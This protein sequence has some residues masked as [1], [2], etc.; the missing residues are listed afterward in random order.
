MAQFFIERPV[1]SWVIAISIMLFGALS[2]LTLPVSMYPDIAP[3]VVS[4]SATYVGATAQTLESS[5]TQVI[6]QQLQGLDG[7]MYFSATSDVSGN[8][9][10]QLTFDPSVN[11]DIAQ[12]QVMN[13]VQL[14]MSNLPEE[15]QNAGVKVEK[16]STAFMCMF[17]FISTDGSMK[18]SDIV[19]YVGT[20][21]SDTLARVPGVGS[22]RLYGSKHAIRIWLDPERLLAY[23]LVP[24]DIKEAVKAQNAQVSAGQLGDLP[25]TDDTG[26]NIVISAQEKMTTPEEFQKVILRTN[27][28]GSLLRLED[29][30]RVEMGQERYDTLTRYNGETAAG[31]GVNLASGANALDTMKRLV[32]KLEQ[33][34]PYFPAGMDYRIVFDTTP[35]VQTSIMGVVETL[36]EAIRLVFLVLLVFL[37]NWRATLIPSLAVPVVLLGTFAVLAACGFSVNT[38]TLFGMVLAIGLL[39]DDAIV[40]VENVERLMTTEKLSPRDATKK[41]M[42]QITG[43]IT[44]IA[45]VLAAVFLPMAFFSGSVGVI[46]RQFSITIVSAMFLSVATAMSF[47]PSLCATLL[48]GH[49]PGVHPATPAGCTTNLSGLAG[50]FNRRFA[51]L[52]KRYLSCVAAWLRHPKLCLLLYVLFLAAMAELFHILPTGFLP[53]EDQG[54]LQVTFILPQTSPQLQTVEVVKNIEK[55]FMEQESDVV[56]RMIMSLGFSYSGEGQ[57]TGQ[58]FITLRDWSERHEASRRAEAVVARANRHFADLKEARVLVTLPPA[59]SG[60]GTSSG[61]D[62]QLEDRAGLGNDAL[63][64]AQSV[65]LEQ[66][67]QSPLLSTMRMNGTSDAPQLKLHVDREKAGML[68]VSLSDVNELISTA[69][70]GSYFDRFIDN[71]SVKRVYTQADAPYR[72]NT[73]DF[74]RWHVRNRDGD[75]VPLSAFVT[76]SWDYGPTR[77]ERY[78][79]FPSRGIQGEAASGV[80]TG[81]AMDEMER[82]SRMLPEGIGFEWTGISYQE[83]LSGAQAAPLY[84]ISLLVIFLALAALYESW[85]VP[86]AVLLLAP[87]GVTG[88]LLAAWMRGMNNDI[89]FQVA[90]L[91]TIGLAAK[92]AIL[93]VEFARDLQHSGMELNAATLKACELRFRP[94]LMTSLAFLLGVFPLAVSSGAGSGSQNSIGTGILGGTL[95]ATVL[96]VLFVPVFY[97]GLMAVLGKIR[98]R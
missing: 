61:F 45:V 7:L 38:L 83:K 81:A 19:D 86:F 57:N 53:V 63:I 39:V 47:T 91:T 20:Y 52:T 85:T 13:K 26:L 54:R 10:M 34:K 37:Q 3:P 76:F 65:L 28:D 18:S 1:F 36:I 80:S 64:K 49:D 17:A 88:A 87:V 78:N 68:G 92:N 71:N 97:A 84:A 2:I 60:L 51:G 8:V 75:L 4:V 23:N 66:A 96:G 77:L 5:V 70:G 41:T 22:V 32:D 79:A 25:Q 46:Y 29:V 89:Y 9:R 24:D 40:V 82:L 67:Q 35:F 56:D 42:K 90:I 16:A 95:F 94:I 50:T 30:A 73:E 31:F 14:A 72:M 21:I 59:I 12:T 15:V 98:R 58:G 62:F 44:G 74:G 55:Y 48:R 33:M 43:A 6:E 27:P 69:W 11:P 93:I